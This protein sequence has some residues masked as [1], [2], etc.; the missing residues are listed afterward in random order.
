MFNIDRKK[1]TAE[2][3]IPLYK[4][5]PSND[6]LLSIRQ[7]FNVLSNYPI[8]V[9]KPAGLQLDYYPFHFDRVENFE[10]KYFQGIAGYNS[11]MLSEDFYV[12]FLQSSY[13]LIYQT[14]AFVFSDQL[15]YWCKQNYDYI[16]APWLYRD[17][18]D[19]AKFIKES[20]RGWAHRRFNIKDAV[21]GLPAELQ[22]HNV[23]GNGGFSLRKV[24]L[25]HR[26]CKKYKFLIDYYLQHPEK[27][28]NED[29][30]WSIE[31]NRKKRH[32]RVPDY[33]KALTFSIESYPVLAWS[34]VNQKLPFGCHG[35]DKCRDFWKPIFKNQGY[36]I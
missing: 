2:I 26:I 19:K 4:E 12:K 11:L 14:D 22:F 25:F 15:D 33:K 5:V 24:E 28:F 3:I 29:V 27:Q 6:D 16:G 9:V 18:V 23:V 36:D 31:I 7:C 17:Y 20:I 21:S 35:W 34:L 8:V 30:F 1:H 32:L 13:I 10:A